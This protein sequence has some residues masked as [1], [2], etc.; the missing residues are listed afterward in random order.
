VIRIERQ[1][2][3]VHPRRP[4]LYVVAVGVADLKMNDAADLNHDGHVTGEE[5]DRSGLFKEGDPIAVKR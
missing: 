2:G 5:L 4:N 3:Q 1:P